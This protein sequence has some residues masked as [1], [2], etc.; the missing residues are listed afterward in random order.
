MHISGNSNI[1]DKLE[2]FR[3]NE[4]SEHKDN[5]FEMIKM[6]ETYAR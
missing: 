3:T 1:Y 2:G 5:L 4:H 6:Y